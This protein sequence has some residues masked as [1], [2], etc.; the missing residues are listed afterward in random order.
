M[1]IDKETL[2]LMAMR[3]GKTKG[4]GIE[5]NTPNPDPKA[6]EPVRNE[7]GEIVQVWYDQPDVITD[8]GMTENVRIWLD[9][10]KV[11]ENQVKSY[12]KKLSTSG[13]YYI[14]PLRWTP[15]EQARINAWRKKGGVATGTGVNGYRTVAKQSNAG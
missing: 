7:D 2:K 1:N 4:G 12:Q 13:D 6:D 10:Q 14:K 3:P 8:E 9:R 5:M 11:I 15:E